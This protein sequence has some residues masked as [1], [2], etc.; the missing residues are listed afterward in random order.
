[1]HK[2][3]FLLLSASISILSC[4]KEVTEKPNNPTV[5]KKQVKKITASPLDYSTFNYDING[6][7]ISRYHQWEIFG[8]MVLPLL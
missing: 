5:S 2:T 8:G 7:L 1:M 6:K 4:K 3:L